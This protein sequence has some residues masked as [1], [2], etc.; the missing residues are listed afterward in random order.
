M[1]KF[2]GL[3]KDLDS[4]NKTTEKISYITR[5]LS[6]ANDSD[7]L[8]MI[9]LLSGGRIKKNFT[10]PELRQ[11]TV[12]ASGIP[13]WLFDES[14]S[15]VGDLAET[16]SLVISKANVISEYSLSELVGM[17]SNKTKCEKDDTKPSVE[18]NFSHST[19]LSQ[20]DSDLECLPEFLLTQLPRMNLLS[21]M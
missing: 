17:I 19:N 1:R 21:R 3:L 10:T 12:E 2:A 13:Q 18:V 15:F 20:A 4:T 5:Y 11:W 16:I 7:R 8:W 14:Y 9:F 6:T